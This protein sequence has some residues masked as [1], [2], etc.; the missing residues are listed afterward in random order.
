[1]L[2]YSWKNQIKREANWE[3]KE[4]V[5]RKYPHSFNNWGKFNFLG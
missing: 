3:L 2:N 5:R 1:M 4:E